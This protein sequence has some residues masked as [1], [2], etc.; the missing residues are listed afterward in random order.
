[1]KLQDLSF[2]VRKLGRISSTR[3]EPDG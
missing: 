2:S 1:M 3:R